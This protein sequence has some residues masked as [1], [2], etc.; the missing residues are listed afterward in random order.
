MA[1]TFTIVV[2][3][4]ASTLWDL[5]HFLD[6]AS[7]NG[8]RSILEEV[9]PSYYGTNSAP[10]TLGMCCTQIK[11]SSTIY[12]DADTWTPNNAKNIVI[13]NNGTVI[14][15][16]SHYGGGT[17]SSN[18]EVKQ[19]PAFTINNPNPNSYDL[20]AK[21]TLRSTG[22]ST[23]VRNARGGTIIFYFSIPDNYIQ[24]QYVSTSTK[25]Y[26][27]CFDLTSLLVIYI[28]TSSSSGSG[29][30]ESAGD[31]IKGYG[32]G[33]ISCNYRTQAF[34]YSYEADNTS[35][36]VIAYSTIT[37]MIQGKQFWWR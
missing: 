35:G 3:P 17:T 14:A 15:Q 37:S 33:G 11:N 4:G 1:L 18:P 5:T 26:T 32:D 7:I 31:I 34:P 28:R 16:G 8:D 10:K 20:L 27:G 24:G 13:K 6:I 21:V 36:T 29:H 23:Y 25:G 12:Y 22:G 19:I 9:H 30:I 2:Q